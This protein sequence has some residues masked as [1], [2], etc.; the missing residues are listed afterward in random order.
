M[1]HCAIK[2]GDRS[3]ATA[4]IT[5]IHPY[6]AFIFISCDLIQSYNNPGNIQP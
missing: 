6:F 1:E 2:S 4:I 5:I 3:S